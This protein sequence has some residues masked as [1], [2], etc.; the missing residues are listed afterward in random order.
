MIG[1]RAG[2]YKAVQNKNSQAEKANQKKTYPKQRKAGRE[3]YESS[4]FAEEEK[5]AS[6]D[7]STPQP[8]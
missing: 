2:V 5:E 7:E 6:G 1:G 3:D 4:A 8:S